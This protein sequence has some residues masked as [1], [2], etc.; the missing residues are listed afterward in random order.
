MKIDKMEREEMIK[1]LDKL[2]H[3]VEIDKMDVNS[4]RGIIISCVEDVDAT[5]INKAN[6]KT[7][8]KTIRDNKL[9]V[10]IDLFDDDS[11]RAELKGM[12]GPGNDLGGGMS[13]SGINEEDLPINTTSVEQD[14]EEKDEE[15]P[16]TGARLEQIRH[17][18][19]KDKD[20]KAFDYE[21]KGLNCELCGKDRMMELQRQGLLYG[22][23]FDG[24]RVANERYEVYYK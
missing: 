2:G 23:A 11:I 10:D 6:K 14:G 12:M 20:A 21:A 17:N 1:E 22:V 8:I 7:L 18:R 4:L 13:E 9:V 19:F 24:L 16:E 5:K 15:S 3:E